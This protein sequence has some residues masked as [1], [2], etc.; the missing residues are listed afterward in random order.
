MG[1]PWFK[2][3]CEEYGQLDRTGTVPPATNFFFSK[4]VFEIL[5][6]FFTTNNS[7]FQFTSDADVLGKR[8]CRPTGYFTFDL[9]KKG[10]NW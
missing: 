3:N 1:F 5:V 7:Q 9:D 2:P 8:L 4:P 10:R 6:L